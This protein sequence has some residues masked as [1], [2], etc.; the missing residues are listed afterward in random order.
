MEPG[1]LEVSWVFASLELGE[2]WAC[3]KAG[4]SFSTC[5]SFVES[6]LFYSSLNLG[7]TFSLSRLADPTGF[8]LI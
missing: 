6:K 5:T 4:R 8:A 1:C 2:C 3:C 7:K